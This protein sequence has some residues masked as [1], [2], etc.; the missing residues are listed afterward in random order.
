[1]CIQAYYVLCC[2]NPCI[3]SGFCIKTNGLRL[4]SRY[5]YYYCSILSLYPIG[6]DHISSI[7]IDRL[8][9]YKNVTSFNNLWDGYMIT[10]ITYQSFF[11]L[12]LILEMCKFLCYYNSKQCFQFKS[13]MLYQQEPYLQLQ[14]ALLADA[15]Y[16]P[17]L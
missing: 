4:L 8:H 5:I 2:S 13:S 1:M 12:I 9:K 17:T 11:F 16:S 14:Q 15:I 10:Q 3:I 7:F 6:F